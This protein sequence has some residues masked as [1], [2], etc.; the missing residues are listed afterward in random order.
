MRPWRSEDVCP[1]VPQRPERKQVEVKRSRQA[2]VPSHHQAGGEVPQ[3]SRSSFPGWSGIS[4]ACNPSSLT[5]PADLDKHPDP[6]VQKYCQ[7]CVAAMPKKH[8]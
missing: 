4:S 1:C 5:P 2:P 7:R 8:S 3:R 6:L